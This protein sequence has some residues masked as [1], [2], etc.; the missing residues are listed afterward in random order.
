M[1]RDYT[2]YT[3][4]GL[5]E[6]LNK[7]QLVFTI[8]KDWAAKNKPSLEEIQ[9]TFPE[10]TQGSKGFIVKESEVKDAKRFN[11][12]EPLSIKITSS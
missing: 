10:E 12:E 9:A 1:A 3:V 6:K 8:V 4:E 11:M 2:K 5:G 7:R